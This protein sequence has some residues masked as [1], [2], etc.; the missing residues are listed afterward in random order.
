MNQSRELI[1]PIFPFA[2]AAQLS[3]VDL[4][5]PHPLDR[6]A[7]RQRLLDNRA[8]PEDVAKI[9]NERGEWIYFGEDDKESLWEL[10][11]GEIEKYMVQRLT[12]VYTLVDYN[13][14]GEKWPHGYNRHNLENHVEIVTH[15]SYP[16]LDAAGFGEEEKQIA[17]V[18]GI[19]HDA[20]NIIDRHDHSI[21]SSVVVETVAPS[22]KRDSAKYA[23]AK[24]AM[25][26]HDEKKMYQAIALRSMPQVYA[27][28]RKNPAL[29][30]VAL[31][32]KA[33]IGR[34]RTNPWARTKD[35][36]NHDEHMWVNY[37]ADGKGYALSE[38]RKS[39]T[40]SIE[41]NPH[42]SDQEYAEF[43]QIARERSHHE[44]YRALVPDVIQQLHRREQ[45]PHFYSWAG[46]MM[47]IYLDR[48]KLQA[49]LAKSLFPDI[50]RFTVELCDQRRPGSMAG[51]KFVEEFVYNEPRYPLEQQFIDLDMLYKKKEERRPLEYQ[52]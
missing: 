27:M 34:H 15:M 26:L 13:L 14:L 39:L 24:E 5:V 11:H 8:N 23:F 38:D 19:G 6:P 35:T 40:L 10:T 17:A 20:G 31:A 9:F 16:L 4:L 41:F 28:L 1:G 46:K 47:M 49:I 18:V 44:G 50:E 52:Q 12:P 36:I 29:V 21:Y 37:M 7:V 45:I 42:I 2:E 33:D 32:D 25:E 22:V 48:I 51:G 3:S 30:A 43:E